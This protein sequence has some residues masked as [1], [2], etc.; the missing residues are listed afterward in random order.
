MDEPKKKIEQYT[1]KIEY[2]EETVKK[3]L[4]KCPRV[5]FTNIPV[6]FAIEIIADLKL[7]GV[8]A[9]RLDRRMD[10]IEINKPETPEEEATAIIRD[11]FLVDLGITAEPIEIELTN[12][13]IRSNIVD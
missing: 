1:I 13:T 4:E 9:R 5:I 6:I 10:I 12:L 2:L 8:I 11:Y 7:C 3:L